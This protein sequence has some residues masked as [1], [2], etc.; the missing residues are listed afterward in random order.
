MIFFGQVI[1]STTNYPREAE[2]SDN[3]Y[4]LGKITFLVP[5]F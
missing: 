5:I 1:L 2:Q 4:Y 3:E